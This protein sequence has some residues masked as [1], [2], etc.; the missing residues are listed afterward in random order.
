MP[1]EKTEQALVFNSIPQTYVQ[2]YTERV[3]AGP[4]EQ[5]GFGEEDKE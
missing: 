1:V 4:F 3:C 2:S 5:Q